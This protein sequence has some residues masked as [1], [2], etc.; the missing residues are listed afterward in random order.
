MYQNHLL[1][2][3]MQ[4]NGSPPLR[5][6]PTS[7]RSLLLDPVKTK[8]ALRKHQ[9]FFVRD[10]FLETNDDFVREC[11]VLAGLKTPLMSLP[12][13]WWTFTSVNSDY[14]FTL[15]KRE[16]QSILCDLS[17]LD[18][19]RIYLNSKMTC[20]GHLVK[21]RIA[22]LP[23]ITV[24]CERARDPDTFAAIHKADR[25]WRKHKELL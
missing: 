18:F 23:L 17:P 8:S 3:L 5:T 1:L 15:T 16:W 21:Q 4:P 24:A 20:I 12:Q 10:R 11:Y 2:E 13:D 19:S 22:V 6:W 25:E 14:S 7:Y 9:L